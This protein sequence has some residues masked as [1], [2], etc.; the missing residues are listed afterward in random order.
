ML[1][2][3]LTCLLTATPAS[4]LH[5]ALADL[6][7]LPAHEQ[8]TARYLT[9]Y[10]LRPADRAETAAVISFVL[11]SISRTGTIIR[12][13]ALAEGRILRLSL[14]WYGLPAD[15]WEAL[16]SDREPYLHI[17]TQAI[18]PK[19]RRIQTV[20]TDGGWL[21]LAEAAELRATT[22]SGGAIVRGDWFVS[23]VS[24]PPHYY[25]FAGVAASEREFL[26]ALGLDLSVISNLSA[27][28]GANLIFSQVTRKVRRV[29]RR[30]GP[31]GGA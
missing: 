31:L 8:R 12:P 30:P 1:S 13:A 19:T 9:L 22:H 27:D 17:T 23:R 11:N 6:R 26:A 29:V 5:C 24:L 28:A 16:V 7:C 20:Y 10:N 18:D 25:Q 21:N 14:D 15:V 3:M 4:E 2:I